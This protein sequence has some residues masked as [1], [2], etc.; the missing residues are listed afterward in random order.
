MSNP[1]LVA[2]WVADEPAAVRRCQEALREH[3][4]HRAKAAKQLKV[5]LRQLYRWLAQYPAILRGLDGLR[6][7]RKPGSVTA[8][9]V[10]QI[11]KR[12]ADGEPGAAVAR[13][14]GLTR[15]AVSR[16]ANGSRRS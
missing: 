3:G 8:A 6:A 16:I 11:R 1:K 9:Q 12:V 14:L 4:G 10:R 13:D 5:S 2:L 7:A 15:S